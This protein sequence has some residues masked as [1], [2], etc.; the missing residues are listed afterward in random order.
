MKKSRREFL[1]STGAVAVIG[2]G[3]AKFGMLRETLA[4]AK[5][6]GK[7]LFNERNLNS[8]IPKD[9]K[10][11]PNW[12]KGPT[13]DLKAWLKER[14]QFTSDQESHLNSLTSE[15]INKIKDALRQASAKKAK[16]SVA[17]VRAQ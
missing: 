12:I 7:Q 10:D 17:L 1:K 15:H 13:G 6:Q 16:L 2:I 8:I 3:A 9:P 5:S 11:Y 14:F 4:V